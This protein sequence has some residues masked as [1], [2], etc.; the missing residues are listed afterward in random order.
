[1]SAALLGTILTASI[2]GSLHCAGMC[3][4]FVA[5]YA[6]QPSGRGFSRRS[7]AHA[8]YS[9]GR[10]ASYLALGAIAGAV[11]RGVDLAGSMSG[12]ANLAALAAGSL[13]VAWGLYALLQALDV[14]LPR[15][16]LPGWLGRATSRV[17]GGLRERPPVVRA[18]LLGLVSTLLPCGWLYSF[19]VLGAGTGSVAGGMMVMTA[20]WLGTL[21]M[22]LGFGVSLH[23]LSAPLRRRLPAV[24]ASLLI[25]VGLLWLTGR[26]T[27]P[28]GN[29]AGQHQHAGQA[30]APAEAPDAH[31][32]HASDGPG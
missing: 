3:G 14:R 4:G 32:G 30:T 21:P 23:A 2:A 31:A 17:Y 29:H 1:M 15:L 7:L 19:A 12:V 10:L 28:H 8:A 27:M 18:L 25:V 11:G 24:T 5:F 9:G 16:P 26:T 6:G 22:M 20:F 13:M